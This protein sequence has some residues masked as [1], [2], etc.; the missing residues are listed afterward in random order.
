MGQGSAS[1]IDRLYRFGPFRLDADERRLSRAG[2]AVP[3]AR[4]VFDL[5]LLLVESAGRLRTREELIEALWPNSI[6]GEQGL[7][8]KVHALRK[9]LGDE[10][11]EPNYVETVRGIGYRFV[12][13]VEVE[14]RGTSGPAARASA[15][16][17]RRWWRVGALG[18][19][20]VLIVA[21]AGLAYE[22]FLSAPKGP[23]AP[24]RSIAVLPFDNL[25]ADSANAYFVSGVQDEILTRLAAIRNLRVIARAST[26]GYA[27]HPEDL[28]A[29]AR[30]LG[31]STVLEGSV[32]KAG[33]TVHINV[34]LVDARTYA[35]IWAHSYD[36]KLDDVFDV[37]GEVAQEIADALR[38]K[39][40]PREAA[41]LARPPTADSQAY[42]FYLKANYL[43]D[44]VFGEQDAK[45]PASAERQAVRLYHRA[46]SIDPGFAIAYARLSLMESRAFWFA[47][48]FDNDQHERIADAGRTARKALALDP[49]LPQAH[50]AMGYVQYYARLDYAAALA[51]FEQAR[52]GLPNNAA[53]IAAIGYIHRRQGK[54]RQALAELREAALLDPRNARRAQEVGITQVWMRR[55]APAR[56]T[57]KQVLAIQPHDY[58]ADVRLAEIALLVGEPARVG[59]VLDR[60]PS[61]VKLGGLISALRFGAAMWERKPERALAALAGSPRWQLGPAYYVVPTDLLRA[62]AWSLEGD[63]RRARK[64]YADALAALQTRLGRWPDDETLLASI[65]KAQA[66]LGNGAKAVAAGIRATGILPVGKDAAYGPIYLYALAEIYARTGDAGRAV[67][68]LERLLAT[69]SAAGSL[70]SGATLRL[71][72]VWDAIRSDPRF[73]ALVNRYGGGALPTRAAA[74]EAGTAQ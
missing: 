67:D 31:V 10:G 45:D 56:Q 11:S 22:L 49:D 46:I 53:A 36:R 17:R 66:G 3:L 25:S 20:L 59:V 13:P 57:F 37:E 44:R 62:R 9:A 21:G 71:D 60:I 18:A 65:G 54:W 28:R 1:K 19:A 24:Q 51:Q 64:A 16:P 74:A 41:R 33:D 38:A 29:V 27:S 58:N 68:L 12:A 7:T 4:K 6:V 61:D 73:V 50:L 48:S 47:T 2:E 69:P 32:Q 63:A 30:E 39:L 43:A 34:Q 40:L 55:Y 35:H 72:P 15:M 23:G 8:T 52:K 14:A 70:V 26:A 42:L 5:L